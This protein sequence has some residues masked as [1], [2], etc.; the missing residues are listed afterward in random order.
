[1][2][3]RLS[4]RLAKEFGVEE[5][6]ILLGY[7]SEDILKQVVHC[8]LKENDRIMIPTHSW[9]YYRSIADEVKGIKVEYP[10]IAGGSSYLYDVNSMLKIHAQSKPKVI[11]VSS[12]NN[13]TGNSISVDDLKSLLS[14]IGD[15]IVVLDEAYWGFSSGE[16]HI[17]RDLIEKYPHLLIIRTFSKYYALAG[18][19]IGFAF[20]GKELGR[21]SKFSARYLG[22]NRLSEG[23]ALAALDSP[24]YYGQIKNKMNQ[25]KER[26]YG[27]LGRL[28]GFKVYRSDANFIL[29]E[30]PEEIRVH[31]KTSLTNMGLVV[32]FFEEENVKNYVRITI[33]TEKQNRLLLGAIKSIAGE[34]MP[35]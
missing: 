6:V 31:L 12:P 13:P 27:A 8:Y 4:E 16:N 10:L 18:A 17:V 30:I 1:V 11:L 15:T 5:S 20:V 32:K 25:D 35:V 14:K 24:D 22:Y 19:R 26:Y 9:W 33:G 3:S 2:K 28:S 21:L 34:E 23:L 7:G 29:V